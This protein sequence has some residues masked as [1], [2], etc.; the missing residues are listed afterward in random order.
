M[1]LRWIVLMLA[2]HLL[3]GYEDVL[4]D[5]ITILEP[6]LLAASIAHTLPALAALE[7]QHTIAVANAS[8]FGVHGSYA[9]AQKGLGGGHIQDILLLACSAH[10]AG[11]EHG[12]EAADT[13][14]ERELWSSPGT[15]P[16]G[17]QRRMET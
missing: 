15:E 6:S 7:N 16:A 11:G 8:R 14:N 10:S 1:G 3:E 12:Q 4:A 2:I 13:N 9:I 5:Q 17:R